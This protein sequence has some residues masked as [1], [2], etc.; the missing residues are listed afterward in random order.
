MP[1]HSFTEEV[2]YSF[3]CK[4]PG[5]C[6]YDMSKKLNMTGGRVRHALIKLEK[7]GLVKFKFDNSV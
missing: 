3:V 5:L 4:H 7:E 1:K 2:V 6:T